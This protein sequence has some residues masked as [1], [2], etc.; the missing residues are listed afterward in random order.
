[1][2][3]KHAALLQAYQKAVSQLSTALEALQAAMAT[4]P[5]QEYTCMRNYVDQSRVSAERARLDLERHLREHG[6][7]GGSPSAGS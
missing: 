6:C 5:Q 2:C 3:E 1:M 4:A 7:E